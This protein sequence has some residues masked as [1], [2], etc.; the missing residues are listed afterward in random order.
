MKRIFFIVMVLSFS[1]DAGWLKNLY[2]RAGYIGC[3]RQFKVD[4]ALV[5]TSSSTGALVVS[6]GMGAPHATLDSLKIGS[7]SRI[8]NITLSNDSLK[9]TVGGVTK[10]F[11][12]TP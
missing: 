1:V 9:I 5:S 2:Q 4:T 10:K 6:G 3:T 12:A 8:T 7:G 11:V